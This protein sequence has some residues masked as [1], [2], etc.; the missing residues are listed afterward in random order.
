LYKE[1]SL[2]AFDKKTSG[3]DED[4]SASNDLRAHQPVFFALMGTNIHFV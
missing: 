1:L 2:G 3:D 4:F